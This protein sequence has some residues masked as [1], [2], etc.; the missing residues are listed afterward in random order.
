MNLLELNFFVPSAYR[1]FLS[2][3]DFR[4]FKIIQGCRNYRKII[5]D[6][7]SCVYFNENTFYPFINVIL[8]LWAFISVKQFQPGKLKFF[9]KMKPHKSQ[10]C[11]F[12][13]KPIPSQ[14]IR[15]CYS[16]SNE[17]NGILTSYSHSLAQ[18]LKR[19]RCKTFKGRFII[20]N[21]E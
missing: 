16:D 8:T 3:L 15:K 1:S 9:H 10:E 4:L 17:T 7:S 14:K 6:I 21:T 18:M 12:S 2:G 5:P 19:T 11:Y 20:E 13:P